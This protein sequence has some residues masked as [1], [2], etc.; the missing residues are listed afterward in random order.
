MCC[1]F[2]AGR[3]AKTVKIH[4]AK[5]S[6]YTVLICSTCPT[7]VAHDPQVGVT[8]IY[9]TAVNPEPDDIYDEAMPG[10]VSSC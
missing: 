2:A 1:N 9:D 10:P 3:S 6:G 5:F 8:D 4:N 7:I